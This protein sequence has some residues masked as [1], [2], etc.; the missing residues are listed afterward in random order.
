MDNYEELNFDIITIE[1][2]LG[3]YNFKLGYVV[4]NDGKIVELVRGDL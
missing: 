1:D 4:I 2:C 3:L